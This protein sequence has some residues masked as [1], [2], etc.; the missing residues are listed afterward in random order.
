MV[1]GSEVIEGL[2]LKASLS[3]KEHSVS[4]D[5]WQTLKARRGGVRGIEGEVPRRVA[6]RLIV[7]DWA[8][9]SWKEVNLK[10]K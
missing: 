7:I 10:Y 1:P 4:K 3:V 9:E 2:L 5:D 8:I 6:C